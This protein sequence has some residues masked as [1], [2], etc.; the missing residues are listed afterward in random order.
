MGNTYHSHKGTKVNSVILCRG[1][2]Q[3]SYSQK[4]FQFQYKLVHYFEYKSYL[5]KK[6]C[7]LVQNL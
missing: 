2:M 4:L 5:F 3:K 1:Y 7:K 6:K